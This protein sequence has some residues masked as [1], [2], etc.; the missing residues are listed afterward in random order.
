VTEKLFYKDPYLKEF[1]ATITKID[2]NK[3]TLD[4]T[5][6]FPFSGGQAGDIGEIGKC[7]VIN[8][9]YEGEEIVHVLETCLLSV[10]EEVKCEIDWDRRYSIMKLHSAAH[11]V[12][13]F[14]VKKNGKQEVIGSNITDS[15]A[16]LDF[17]TDSNIGIYLENLEKEVNGFISGGHEIRTYENPEK[18]GFRVWA[19]EDMKMP[20]GGTHVKSTSNIGEVCLKRKNL[21]AGKE[22][23][24][25]ELC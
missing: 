25:V 24:E 21:G 13:E 3:V 15:K 22:R 2:G 8:T 12:Y 16:R 7:K 18:E 10:S 5:A 11:L 9:V 14:F 4:R 1:K 6:F 17:K 23:I 19:C 20:C